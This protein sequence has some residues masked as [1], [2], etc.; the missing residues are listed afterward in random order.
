MEMVTVLEIFR[1]NPE[2][3]EIQPEFLAAISEDLK[4]KSAREGYD[5]TPQPQRRLPNL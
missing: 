5:W 3:R 4:E 2:V 1:T